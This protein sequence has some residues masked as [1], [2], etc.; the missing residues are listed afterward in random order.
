MKQPE[1]LPVG[2][3]R[4]CPYRDKTAR[5][6]RGALW[7]WRRYSARMSQAGLQPYLILLRYVGAG[8]SHNGEGPSQSHSLVENAV[9]QVTLFHLGK[10]YCF[11]RGQKGRCVAIGIKA[12]PRARN[13]VHHDSVGTLSQQFVATIFKPILCFGSKSYHQGARLATPDHIGEDVLGWHQLER[14]GA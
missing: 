13:I 6:P 9:C 5:A 12:Q 8:L 2:R 4:R 10:L 3:S 1:A 7:H 14:E 11:L